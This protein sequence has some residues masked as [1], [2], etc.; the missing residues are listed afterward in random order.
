MLAVIGENVVD[1]LPGTDG[2]YRPCLG[3]SPFN[4]AIGA[5][6]QHI[7]V[8]YLSPLSQDHFG[9]QFARYLADNGACYGLPF[10][11]PAPSSLAMVSV[12]AQQQ[13]QYSLY[14]S[15]IA[16]RAVSAE[17]QIAALPGNCKLLHLGSLALE[18]QDAPRIR[19]V[20]QA[21]AA[22]QIFI[23]VDINVRLNAVSDVTA[24]RAFLP[25]VTA[26]SQF[27]K[28]SD[29]DLQLLYPQLS[30]TDALAALRATAPTAL[31]ALTEGDKGATLH[32]QQHQ[33]S[34]AVI[35]ATP[36]VDTVGAG[37]TFWANLLA[38]LLQ[39][40]LPTAAQI[41]AAQLTQCLQQAMLAAS[42]NIARQ[43]CNPPNSAELT[44][45]LLQLQ[46]A[47]D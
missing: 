20:L 22:R 43:G 32:W 44:A 40:G 16:D 36:F 29:E 8:S 25:E 33:I 24:Y 9:Q 31:V 11:S 41:S 47:K 14:R 38:A 10:F 3:G 27:I 1:M 37:D 7:A 4:V 19:A 2:L 26:L 46:T 17:Q 23:S 28:A 35:P 18:P 15:G 42:L 34:L 30:T 6:R 39:L 13:P 21:A 5:A 45:A 12:D